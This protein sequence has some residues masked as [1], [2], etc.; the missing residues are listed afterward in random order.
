[1]AGRVYVGRYLAKENLTLQMLIE[2][3][4]CSCESERLLAG[5]LALKVVER[6]LV[7]SNFTRADVCYAW[8]VTNMKIGVCLSQEEEFGR[9]GTLKSVW[10]A[11]SFSS[12]ALPCFSQ[13]STSSC[14]AMKEEAY[15]AFVAE[16]ASRI[17]VW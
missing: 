16:K 17:R 15:E 6:D 10:V 11:V 4:Y 2:V 5:N 8:D 13:L 7:S 12:S 3:Y 1:M 14:I 9:F